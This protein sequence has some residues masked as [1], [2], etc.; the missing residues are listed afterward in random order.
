VLF[1]FRVLRN[2]YMDNVDFIDLLSD[3]THNWRRVDVSVCVNGVK[4]SV[5]DKEEDDSF[6]TG[7]ATGLATGFATGLATG[8]ATG[9]AT[10]FATGFATGSATG[11]ATGPATGGF[12]GVTETIL[13][14]TRF[15]ALSFPTISRRF[16]P[17]LF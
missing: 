3:G 4:F 15:T 8:F 5:G 9:L 16:R 10:G 17:F 12:T 11:L 7:F 13:H 14:F 1:V 6:T 2:E